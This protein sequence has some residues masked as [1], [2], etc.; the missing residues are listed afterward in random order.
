MFH[1]YA[2]EPAVISTWQSARHF[3]DAF[4][5]WHGRFLAEY[6][7]R[8]R[9]LVFEALTCGDVERHRIV[10]RLN[11]LDRRAWSP[12]Q[13]AVYDGTQN[14]RDNV[15][16]EHKRVPFRAV[17]V[18]GEP[19]EIFIEADSVTDLEPLWRVEPGRAVPRTPADFVRAL[20]LLLQASRHIAIVDPYFRADQ[21]DKLQPFLH[22]CR[23]VAGRMV[24]IDLHACDEQFAHHEFVRVAQR[25]LPGMLPNGM[26]VTLRSWKLRPRGQEFHNRFVMTDVGGV[27]FG[28][29]IE[30]GDSGQSD[31]LSRL[32]DSERTLYWAW[33]YGT[34]A[35]YDLAGPELVVVGTAR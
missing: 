3:L 29:S 10:E 31:R 9:R 13:G 11:A 22:L 2:L 4:G 28:N 33:F 5:P 23:A 6:P 32:G 26:S 1:E 20:D 21:D 16:A 8:W 15:E 34:P 17:V 35:A 25:V 7:R 18:T 19:H 12:R 14:W 27:Q 24:T 30:Q